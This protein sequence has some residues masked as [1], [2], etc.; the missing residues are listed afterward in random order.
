[1][2]QF[3]VVIQQEFLAELTSYALCTL[4]SCF[5]G[6]ARDRLPYF[7]HLEFTILLSSVSSQTRQPDIQIT[8]LQAWLKSSLV[9]SFGKSTFGPVLQCVIAD[10]NKQSDSQWL[11]K[12]IWPKEVTV[13]HVYINTCINNSCTH[14]LAY[15]IRK[16][17]PRVIQLLRSSYGFRLRILKLDQSRGWLQCVSHRSDWYCS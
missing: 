8:P 17:V 10:K 13:M 7:F 16:W 2:P 12:E 6:S 1:M 3:P 9:Q 4:E 5:L 15:M 11:R 14:T